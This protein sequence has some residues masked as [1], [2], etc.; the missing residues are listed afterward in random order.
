MNALQMY[1]ILCLLYKLKS[2]CP[3]HPKQNCYFH[4]FVY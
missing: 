4:Q 1:I 3:F 2:L